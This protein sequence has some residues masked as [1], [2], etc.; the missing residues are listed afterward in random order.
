MRDEETN[1]SKGYGFVSFDCFEASDT[2]LECMNGQY[3][4]NRQIVVQ[5]AF[6]KDTQGD[7]SETAR[8]QGGGPQERHGSR[9]ERMLAAQRRSLQQQQQQQQRRFPYTMMP[10][11]QMPMLPGAGIPSPPMFVP[12]MPTV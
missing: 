5:Y 1:E 8:P 3:L 10:S 9:A 4:G 2:A 11:M 12:Q 7:G 6:K